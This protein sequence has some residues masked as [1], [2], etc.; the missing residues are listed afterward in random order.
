M[1]YKYIG[2]EK[3]LTFD[4][5]R[6]FVFHQLSELCELK[7]RQHLEECNRCHSIYECL[8]RPGKVMK[9]KSNKRAG[10][11]ILTGAMMLICLAGI[12]GGFIYFEGTSDLNFNNLSDM[13]I[14][15]LQRLERGK[16]ARLTPIAPELGPSKEFKLN[17]PVQLLK[18]IDTLTQAYNTEEVVITSGDNK[19]NN[20]PEIEEEHYTAGFRAIYGRITAEGEALQGVTVMVPG[21][22]TAKISDASGKYY[23]HVPDDIA[24]LVF[25][26]RGKQSVKELDPASRK[27]DVD[28]EFEKMVYPEIETHETRPDVIVS[29]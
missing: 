4:S 19:P 23:I 28:L 2:S 24:S 13:L 1:E 11:R 8:A 16:I 9:K 10:S 12:T 18:N 14:K 27:R 21:G 17:A 20:A 15:G 6:R 5:I 29:N 7:A 25:I 26:Y 3:H 22:S